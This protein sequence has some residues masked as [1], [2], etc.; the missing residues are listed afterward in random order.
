MIRP[1]ARRREQYL[2]TPNARIETYKYLVGPSCPMVEQQSRN[3]EHKD[4][5]MLIP[6]G[7]GAP[8]LESLATTNPRGENEMTPEDL[9]STTII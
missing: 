7:V 9:L 2:A 3:H 6:A 5:N 8:A 4:R 1:H